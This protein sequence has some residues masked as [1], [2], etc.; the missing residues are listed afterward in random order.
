[1]QWSEIKRRAATN[2]A[3]RRLAIGH[4]TDAAPFD[5]EAAVDLAVAAQKGWDEAGAETQEEAHAV[6]ASDGEHSA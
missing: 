4:V 3:D 1:M 2:P 6:V 5:I